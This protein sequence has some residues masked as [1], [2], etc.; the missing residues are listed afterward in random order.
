MEETLRF[1]P[2]VLYK[3]MKTRAGIKK[4]RQL[5]PKLKTSPTCPFWNEILEQDF[6]DRKRP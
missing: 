6:D 2:P 5:T 3:S 4:E 1:F